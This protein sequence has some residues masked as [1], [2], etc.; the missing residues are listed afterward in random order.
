MEGGRGRASTAM[1]PTRI[2]NWPPRLDVILRH[3]PQRCG[4][5][6]GRVRRVQAVHPLLLA[7]ARARWAGRPAKQRRFEKPAALRIMAA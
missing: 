4:S 6:R 3:P 2:C 1:K 5:P 7:V